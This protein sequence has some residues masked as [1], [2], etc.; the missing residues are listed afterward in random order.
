VGQGDKKNINLNGFFT[1]PEI[2]RNKPEASHPHALQNNS[3]FLPANH[4]SLFV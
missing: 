3:V 2:F 4:Q 1:N